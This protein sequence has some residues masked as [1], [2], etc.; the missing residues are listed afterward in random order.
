[1]K[2]LQ[3]GK[4]HGI[5]Q[6][7]LIFVFVLTLIGFIGIVCLAITAK[8]QTDVKT[9]QKSVR[10]SADSSTSSSADS[11]NTADNDPVSKSKDDVD[12]SNP[13]IEIEKEQPSRIALD[14]Y[15]KDINYMLS[16]IGGS[17]SNETGDHERWIIADDLQ[18][19]NYFES[20][21]VDELITTSSAYSLFGVYVSQDYDE[22]DHNLLNHGW[23]FQ[24]SKNGHVDY[25]RESWRFWVRVDDNNSI[26]SM[27]FYKMLDFGDTK[28][29]SSEQPSVE[30]SNQ[31][32]EATPETTNDIGVEKAIELAKQKYGDSLSY[33]SNLTFTL[34]GMKYYVVDVKAHVE[35]HLTRLTQILVASDGSSAKEGFYSE[36]RQPEFY[37]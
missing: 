20:S 36:G 16:E 18:Y 5:G 15:I 24:S 33:F 17:P 21:S 26:I 2:N 7:L 11:D 13:V 12:E 8:K 25:N 30:E 10:S 22:A 34:N 4:K 19:G 23:S 3:S 32:F 31:Q 14:D 29:Q 6:L 1:M 9:N 28:N 35:N 27:G 37:E